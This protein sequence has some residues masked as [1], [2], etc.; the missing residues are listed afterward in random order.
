MSITMNPKSSF[1]A[2]VRALR[3]K[4]GW[5]QERLAAEA[6]LDRTYVGGIEREMESMTNPVARFRWVDMGEAASLAG[7][8]VPPRYHCSIFRHPLWSNE[9]ATHQMEQ[10]ILFCIR[11]GIASDIWR[12][13]MGDCTSP[14]K[15]RR[16]I[17]VPLLL[18][19]RRSGIRRVGRCLAGRGKRYKSRSNPRDRPKI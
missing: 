18:H 1:G 16:G 3:T 19:C 7:F 9:H 2:R 15:N 6:N 12:R 11:R 17:S 10:W 14:S 13:N 8:R 5:S 4:K